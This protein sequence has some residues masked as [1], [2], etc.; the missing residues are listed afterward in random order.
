V[1]ILHGFR[2]GS[3]CLEFRTSLCASAKSE[4]YLCYIRLGLAGIQIFELG[5]DL[6]RRPFFA[7]PPPCRGS[8]CLRASSWLQEAVHLP[9][10]ETRGTYPLLLVLRMNEQTPILTTWVLARRVPV[11]GR[12]VAYQG[13]VPVGLTGP[14]RRWALPMREARLRKYLPFFPAAEVGALHSCLS[15]SICVIPHVEGNLHALP[16][17][18]ALSLTATF[19]THGDDRIPC[20]PN[21]R[22]RL[23]AWDSR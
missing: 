17:L 10:L 8:S 21:T 1:A 9:T 15:N 19:L 4:S 18:L 23:S 14:R 3:S 12:Q 7:G 5:P 16:P 22:R 13:Y 6:A 20:E 2:V 11:V